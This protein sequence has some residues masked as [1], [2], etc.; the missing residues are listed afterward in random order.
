MDA[1]RFF[2][3]LF[4]VVGHAVQVIW[5]GR[6]LIDPVDWWSWAFTHAVGFGQQAVMIFFVLSGFWIT[7]SVMRCLDGERF[8]REFLTDRLTRLH[9]VIVPTLALGA[10]LDVLGE[11]LFHGSVYWGGLGL[12]LLADGLYNH[13]TPAVFAGNLV[14]L[15]GF[16]MNEVGTNAPL[17]SVAYEFWYYV[18]FAA[19]AASV[20]RRRL[21]LVC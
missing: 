11:R 12:E 10:V 20:A 18:W 3:A 21:S 14:F 9:I 1:M 8:W 6:A 15:Q 13:L 2:A 5:G 7:R 16:A 19:L 4:V 17:W